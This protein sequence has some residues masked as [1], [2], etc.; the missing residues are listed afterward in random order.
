MYEYFKNMLEKNSCRSIGVCSIHPSVN[1]LYEILLNEIRESSFY[2]VKLKEFNLINKEIISKMIEALSIFLVNTSFN[3]TKYLKL[4]REL[5]NYKKEIKQRHSQYCSLYQ[6]PC[7]TITTGIV[8][9]DKTTISDLIELAQSYIINKQKNCNKEK[10]HMFDLIALFAKLSAINIIKLKNLNY[11]SKE[12]IEKFSYETIRFFSLTNGYSIRN[13]KIKRRILEFCTIALEI[14]KELSLTLEN[15]YGIK[16]KTDVSR[17]IL[18]G[19]GILVSG[20]DLNELEEV[21]RQINEADLD[22]ETK[23]KIN[24]YTNGALFM[25]HFY[26]C[27]KENKFLKG[28]FGTNEAEFDFS[29][30]KGAILLTQNFVQKIDNLYRGD[31]FS[32]KLISFE[33]VQ[34]I[35]F[36]DYEPLILSSLETENKIFEK[37]DEIK[38]CYDFEKTKN[39]FQNYSKDEIILIIGQINKSENFNLNEAVNLNS[40]LELDMIFDFIKILKEKQVKITILFT[41][42]NL[43]NIEN[44]LLLLNQKINI[45]LANCS[46]VLINPHI[47]EALKKEFEVKFVE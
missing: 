34:D 25:A 22:D 8:I 30:F 16:E 29:T 32:N 23:E 33:R 12:K 13:E 6:L 47:I 28:H 36:E 26:P 18:K 41:Q 42:C 2:I 10:Q 46:N 11:S 5:F 43:T 20:D 24:V 37:K 45:Y 27:F 1:S 9:D 38:S 17:N 15:K 31:I 39:I 3:K 4:V 21:L 35:E 19:H 40:P 44:V 7:E 14:K